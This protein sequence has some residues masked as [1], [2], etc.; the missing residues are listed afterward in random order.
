MKVWG[1]ANIKFIIKSHFSINF[2]TTCTDAGN[3]LYI[4]DDLLPKNSY[5]YWLLVGEISVDFRTLS[6][7]IKTNLNTKKNAEF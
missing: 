3:N 7:N 2:E 6:N 5:I 4:N 1:I